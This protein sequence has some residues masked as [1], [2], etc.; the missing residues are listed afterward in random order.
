VSSPLFDEF[1]AAAAMPRACSCCTWSRIRAINGETT[2]V[3]PLR[4][5]AGN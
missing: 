1:K 4:T 5:I 3:N 2:M